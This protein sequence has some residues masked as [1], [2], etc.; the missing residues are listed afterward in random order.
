MDDSK[1]KLTEEVRTLRSRLEKLKPDKPAHKQ[2]EEA[3]R[4]I[5]WAVESATDAIGMADENFNSIYHNQAFIKLFGYTP[6]ELNAAGGPPAVYK[7]PDDAHEVLEAMRTRGSWNGELQMKTRAGD[8]VLMYLQANAVKDDSGNN[9][10]LVGIHTNITERK[11][12]EEELKESERKFRAAVENSPDFIVFVKRDGTIY[13]VNRLEK[14]FTREMVI[15]KSIFDES[16]YETKEQAKSIKKQLKSVFRTGKLGNY[17]YSQVSPEGSRSFYETRVAPFE[18]DTKNGVISIQCATR[19]IAERKKAEEELAKERNL[20]R[21]LI[22]NLPDSV[23]VK[24]CKNRLVLSNIELA[25]RLGATTPDELLGK[26]DFDFFPREAAEQYYADEQEI[27]RTGR[28]L[29]D[30]ERPI[31]DRITSRPM[32]ISS[33]R[34]P[35]RDSHGRITGILGVGRDITERKRAEEVLRLERDNFINILNSMEDGVYIVDQNC[36]IQYVNPMLERGFGPPEGHKCYQYFH[37]RKEVC[38]WC[39][40]GK[41]VRWE[42]YSVKNQKTYDLID[43]PLK[44]PDGSISKLEIFRDITERKKLEERL[45]TIIHTSP[46]PTAVG[47][48]DGSITAFN[49]ALETLIGYKYGKT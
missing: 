43:T 16:W 34:L 10:G 20:L 7:N 44:N 45:S 19:D 38:P 4:R 15:G 35:L 2:E 26:T 37:D 21:T 14:G 46:I 23:Y 22:D 9:V 8:E 11:K 49:E 47:G 1:R 24:D 18:R 30:Q 39:F 48:S 27:I 3:L 32:W 42:W 25:R 5:G 41:T 36:D 13:D 31:I 28:S 29:I 12:A 33:S 17:E 6:E 40:A